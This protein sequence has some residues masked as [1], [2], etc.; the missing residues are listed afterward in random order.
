MLR[1]LAGI[2]GSPVA[3]AEERP[4]ERRPVVK[5][6]FRLDEGE[7]STKVASLQELATK[8]GF[9]AAP[10]GAAEPVAIVSSKFQNN[11]AR[12]LVIVPSAGEAGLWDKALGNRHGALPPLL[13]WAEA[14]SYE[15][16]VFKHDA[17]KADPPTTWDRV[18]KGSPA[19]CVS[20]IV[21]AGMM[22]YVEAALAPVHPLLFTRLRTFCVRGEDA[23]RNFSKLSAELQ[24]H[25]TSA[26]ATLPASWE[27]L[28][29]QVSFQ[30]LFELLRD[31][32]EEFQ[33]LEALKYSGFQTLKENDMPGLK[34][35]GMEA[36]VKRL[37][38]DRDND[39]LARL[40]RKH[41][42]ASGRQFGGAH[43]EGEEPGID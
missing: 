26:V 38:R 30:V 6:I 34:R 15:V 13:R 22:Q 10:P 29:P 27:Q 12:L 33:N 21:A 8:L 18:L 36:R 39:E 32:E 43:D 9:E 25:L 5:P 17:L 23:L 31:R 28:E 37:D 24:R 1:C 19:G 20:V 41:D 42:E 16:A 40:L 2:C 11:S 4:A 35:M 3:A 14:N 7:D